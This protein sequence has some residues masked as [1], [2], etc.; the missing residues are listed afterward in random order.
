M[1]DFG[2]VAACQAPS[3]DDNGFDGLL[4]SQISI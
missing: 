4:F 1:G 2:L 3:D